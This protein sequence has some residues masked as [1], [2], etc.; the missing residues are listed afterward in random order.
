MSSRDEVLKRVRGQLV[1]AVSHPTLAGD[2]TTYPDPR[3]Q[4]AETL[5]GIGGVCVPVD[6]VSQIQDHLRELLAFTEGQKTVSLISGLDVGNVDPD[7][8]DDP[9]DLEDIDFAVLP[10]RLAVAENGAVWVSD[11]TLKHRVLYFLPQHIALVVEGGHVV[12][13][14]HE[15]Y[16]WLEANSPTAFSKQGFGAWIAGPSKTADIE[17]SLVIGA[18]GARSMTVYLL[19]Q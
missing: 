19:D 5:G 17:Q 7:T 16:A 8:I 18:H 12:S 4:F 1:E 6:N 3:E 14:L 11:E 9:H 10:A 13:N 15:A 2:W